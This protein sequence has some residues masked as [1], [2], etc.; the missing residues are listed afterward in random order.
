MARKNASSYG[1]NGGAF[2]VNIA[3]GGICCHPLKQRGAT[4]K[5][6]MSLVGGRVRLTSVG[7]R[8]EPTIADLDISEIAV[9][10]PSQREAAA[11]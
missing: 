4:C 9:L 7:E 10:K 1:T 6:N 5:V 11:S 8:Q 2:M 3:K